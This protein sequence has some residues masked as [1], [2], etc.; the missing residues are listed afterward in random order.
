MTLIELGALASAL[1]AIITLIT[2]LFNLISAIHQL[3]ARLEFLQTEVN[4]QDLVQ[5][6]LLQL[7]NRFDKRLHSLETIVERDGLHAA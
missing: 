6:Q 7:L 4:R 2:K 3:I 5:E 1:V